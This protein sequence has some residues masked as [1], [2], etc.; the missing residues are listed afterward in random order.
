[1]IEVAVLWFLVGF[2]TC[3]IIHVI[4]TIF[5]EC[6][7]KKRERATRTIDNSYDINNPINQ[8]EWRPIVVNGQTL[9]KLQTDKGEYNQYDWE[10]D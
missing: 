5:K 6:T 8:S 9:Y 2:L 4:C 1:M 10:T 7:T 3:Y